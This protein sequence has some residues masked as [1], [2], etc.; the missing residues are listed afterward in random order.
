MKHDWQTAIRRIVMLMAIST[1]FGWLFGYSGWGLAFG[2]IVYLVWHTY[3][4]YKLQSWLLSQVGQGEKDEQEPPY[5]HGLWGLL[6]D[7]FYRMQRRQQKAQARLQAV[8]QRVQESTAAIKD[9]VLSVN[10]QGNLEWWN[11]SAERLLGLKEAQDKGHPITNLLRAPEFIAYFEQATYEQPLEIPSPTNSDVQLQFHITLFGEKNRLIICRDITHL[12]HLEAMRQ[13]FV[14]N[15]SHEL[16]TPLTVISGYLETFL[17]YSD[18]LPSRWQ[19]GLKQMHT[20]GLRMQNLINDL[21]ILSRLET[22]HSHEHGKVNVPE[23]LASIIQDAQEVSGEKKHTFSIEAQNINLLGIHNELSSA[24]SN[25]IYNA[26]KYT[27][28]G[29]KINIKWFQ[30]SQGIHLQVS[31]NGPG[32][33]SRHLPRLT[34][35]FYRADAS[36]H[37]DT[38]GTG[39]GLAI[40]KHI[41]LHHEGHLQIESTVGRGSCFSCHFP[42]TRVLANDEQAQA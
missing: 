13:D 26:V 18:Q 35:R 3:Q 9:G 21:L 10:Q 33:D 36:R 5:S 19:R 30:D 38:G 6:F 1:G 40:V 29:G 31:D 22:S 4:M 17:E 37:A 34:E 8:L 42:L 25:L 12:H 23:L 11:P 27:Q 41:L 14:A 39:L 24:F 32:I 20:Q 7:D 15:A 28:A 16:R 2:T